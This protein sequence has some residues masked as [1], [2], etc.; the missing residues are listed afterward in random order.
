[1]LAWIILRRVVL[2]DGLLVF[3]VDQLT[4]LGLSEPCESLVSI[5]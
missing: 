3:W 2:L 1:M 5:L 4:Y